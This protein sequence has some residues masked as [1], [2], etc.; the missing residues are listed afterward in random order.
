MWNT[1]KGNLHSSIFCSVVHVLDLKVE[2]KTTI[3]GS[4]CTA[5][6]GGTVRTKLSFGSGCEPECPSVEKMY[7]VCDKKNFAGKLEKHFI[8]PQTGTDDTILINF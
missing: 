2:D 3:H 7:G 6:N 8:D 1:A 4:N 5:I